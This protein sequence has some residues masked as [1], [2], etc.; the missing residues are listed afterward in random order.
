MSRRT[1]RI[2]RIVVPRKTIIAAPTSHH[3]IVIET[4]ASASEAA[5]MSGNALDSGM[6]TSSPTGG[7]FVRST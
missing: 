5:L 6:W 7:R 4:I 3:E 1:S 2:Q